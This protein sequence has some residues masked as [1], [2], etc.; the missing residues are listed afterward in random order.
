MALT[1]SD[2][3]HPELE[4][5]LADRLRKARRNAKMSQEQLC[6]AIG[7]DVED[8]GRYSN[9]ETGKSKPRDLVGT[10]RKIAEATGAPEDWLLGLVDLRR[11]FDLS[12]V[13]DPP[14]MQSQF[15]FP[16]PSA[17]KPVRNADET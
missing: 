15:A 16:E 4:W 3:E 6:E 11:Q 14:V 2:S 8:V 10:I 9:W 17:L 13:P 5:T 7:I 1:N 12:V